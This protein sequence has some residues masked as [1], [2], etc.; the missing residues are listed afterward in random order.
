MT[1][2]SVAAT[3]VLMALLVAACGGGGGDDDS[4]SSG[5]SSAAQACLAAGGHSGP[6][7]DKGVA[8]AAGGSIAIDAIDSAFSP[9]CINKVASGTAQVTVT[10]SGAILHN[11]S[12]A[13][14]GIDEDIGRGESVTI[15]VAIGDTPTV[16]ECKYHR[17]SGMVGALAPAG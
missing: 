2:R 16:Y 3:A 12:I 17:T 9:T 15:D 8:D 10:N 11:V 6:V 1:A 5:G 14:Q 7:T 13:D 4:D